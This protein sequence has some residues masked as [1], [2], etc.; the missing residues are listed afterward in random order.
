MLIF[1]N[2]SSVNSEYTHDNFIKSLF[3]ALAILT[4][5]GY[6]SANYEFGLFSVNIYF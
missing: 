5:T 4:G 3:Q 1:F 6:T 2:I